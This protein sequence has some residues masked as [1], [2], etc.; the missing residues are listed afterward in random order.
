MDYK[1]YY[2]ILGVSK[3]AT[4]KEIKQ[5]YRKL[6]RIHH[7]DKN[8]G[9]KKAEE[10]LKSINEAYEVLGKSENRKKYDQLGQIIT[11]FSKWVG[12]RAILISLILRPRA[13]PATT[14]H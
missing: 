13:W 2:Q 6:A 9:N 14:Q 10:K 7:P 3:S 5:A 11:A 1:D 4:A 12:I 8:P